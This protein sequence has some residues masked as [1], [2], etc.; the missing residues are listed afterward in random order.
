M[1]PSHYEASRVMR[2][3]R[4]F[5]DTATAGLWSGRPTLRGSPEGNRQGQ[6]SVRINHQSRI[7]FRWHQGV[8]YDVEM[9]DYHD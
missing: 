9:V 4:S 1:L 7:C 6:Q 8:P 2:A 3:T 5:A